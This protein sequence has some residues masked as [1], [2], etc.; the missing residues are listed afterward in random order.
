MLSLKIIA[1][2]NFPIGKE[3]IYITY[4]VFFFFSAQLKLTECCVF[5]LIYQC[6]GT[7][8]AICVCFNCFLLSIIDTFL[9][10]FFLN[11]LVKIVPFN[12]SDTKFIN[13]LLGCTFFV[14]C[15][16]FFVISLIFLRK[17]C[18]KLSVPF[19]TVDLLG[20]ETFYVASD[21]LSRNNFFRK[22]ECF[23]TDHPVLIEYI[24]RYVP[25]FL[26]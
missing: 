4:C 20:N 24:N 3:N 12:T 25:F 26:D 9:F 5:L 8:V 6:F 7:S 21:F 19:V 15:F 17:R 13:F 10:Y 16:F 2:I 14:H 1:I 23:L 18:I 11:G 22:D